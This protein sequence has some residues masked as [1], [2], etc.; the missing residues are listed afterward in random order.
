MPDTSLESLAAQNPNFQIAD[1]K[2]KEGFLRFMRRILTWLPEQRPSAKD[3]VFDP[4]LLD[5]L[6]L[7]DEQV[8]YYKKHWIEEDDG[9][10]EQGGDS[11]RES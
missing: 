5:G 4:W 1:E 11:R 8:E 10:E 7:T 3:L 2:D 6:G 9:G